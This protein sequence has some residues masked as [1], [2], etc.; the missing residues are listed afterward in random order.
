MDTQ[1]FIWTDSPCILQDF[2]PFGTAAQKRKK[3]EKKN[4]QQKKFKRQKGVEKERKKLERKKNWLLFLSGFTV[5]CTLNQATAKLIQSNRSTN[6]EQICG[7]FLVADTQLYKRLCPS[8]RP[9]VCQSIR[10]GDRVENKHFRYFFVRWGVDGGWMP[11]PTHPQQ[12]CDP[13]S[14]ATKLLSYQIKSN[15]MY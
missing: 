7:S 5:L 8:V 14:L 6:C 15:C 4:K 11:L 1:T 2:I 12:Y 3:R 13:A 10:H 9:S